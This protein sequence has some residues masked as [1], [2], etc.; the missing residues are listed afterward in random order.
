MNSFPA[1]KWKNKTKDT[2]RTYASWNSMLHRCYDLN[3]VSYK[4]YGARGITVCDR[5]RES[6]DD[7][8]EDM[9]LRPEN[10]TLDRKDNSLGYSSDNCTW[11]SVEYQ[12][13]NKR[14]TKP[15][16]LNGEIKTL[17][18][19]ARDIPITREGV[20]YRLKTGVSFERA[21]DPTPLRTPP[22]HG[23][24]TMGSG[25]YRCTCASCKAAVKEYHRLRYIRLK[26]GKALQFDL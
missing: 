5:W 11:K 25:R 24:A 9:G 17:A 23:T 3:S 12:N 15:R 4:Y 18:E 13:R 8:V 20:A 16:E 6:Y 21:I 2:K 10:M 1:P 14:S 22:K 19:W 26:A 7:F